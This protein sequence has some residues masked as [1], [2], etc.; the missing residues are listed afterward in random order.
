MRHY[1]FKVVFLTLIGD[2]GRWVVWVGRHTPEK[3]S[4]VPKGHLSPVRNRA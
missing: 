4:G 1:P 2:T 3:I